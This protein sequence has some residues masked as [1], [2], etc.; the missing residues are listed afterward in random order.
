MSS[1]TRTRAGARRIRF[2]VLTVLAIAVVV[3]GARL[4]DVLGDRPWADGEVTDD[5]TVFDDGYAAVDNLDPALLTALRQAAT[6]ADDDGITFTVT[7]GWRAPEYQERLLRDAVDEYGSPAEA[8]RWVATAD[9]S[10]HVQGNAVDVGP[11]DAMEWLSAHGAGYGLCQVYANESWHYELRP[12]AVDDGCPAMYDDP[13]HD[14]R[15]Q[16]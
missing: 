14:P 10:P 7:S 6:D 13:T 11:W 3:A 12:D 4:L 15:M 16:Q 2:V 1:S 9:T 5:V 8:A